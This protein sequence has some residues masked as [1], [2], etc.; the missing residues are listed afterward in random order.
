MNNLP[1]YALDFDGVI[2]DSAVETAITG[3][4]VASS[5]WQDMPPSVP[6]DLIEQFKLVRPIIETGYEAILAMRLLYQQ[7]PI[8]SIYENYAV[9]TQA[10]LNETQLTPSDLKHLFGKTRDEWIAQDLADWIKHN[11][12]FT[13]IATKLKHLSQQNTW[14]IVTTKQERFVKQILQ[15]NAIEL[16]ENHIY[17]LDRNMNKPS[18]LK[19]LLEKHPEQEICFVEDRLPTLLNVIQNSELKPIKLIFA[20][21]GYNTL[22]DK[23]LAQQTPISLQELDEFLKF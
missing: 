11:P 7:T 21:W 19:L 23:N 13:D 12:L 2:C 1:I 18:V 20:L 10:S 6:N 4:K 17:G 16:D 5:I 15:A 22:A 8:E 14:Y 9:L 3:W